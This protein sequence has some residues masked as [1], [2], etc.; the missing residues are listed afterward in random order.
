MIKQPLKLQ[1]Y[2][3]KLL[4]CLKIAKKKC[5]QKTVSKIITKFKK[6]KQKTYNL[7]KN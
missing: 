5:I 4:K 1:N 2:L 6:K 7:Q 3:K